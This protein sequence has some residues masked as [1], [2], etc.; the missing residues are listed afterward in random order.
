MGWGGMASEIRRQQKIDLRIE[1]Q[2]SAQSESWGRGDGGCYNR[3]SSRGG[4]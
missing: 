3:A 1:T 2:E 4:E